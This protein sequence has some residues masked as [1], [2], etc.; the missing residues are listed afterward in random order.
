MNYTEILNKKRER[1]S[2]HSGQKLRKK[3]KAYEKA[4]A[5]FG[6]QARQTQRPGKSEVKSERPVVV[7]TGMPEWVV[8]PPGGQP[9]TV[10]AK[11]EKD[12]RLAARTTLGARA[13][14]PGTQV[15]KKS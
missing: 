4:V 8:Q 6:T 7:E 9:F 10:T 3:T 11:N 14:P 15:S 13:L 1:L 12:A 5:R 2:K